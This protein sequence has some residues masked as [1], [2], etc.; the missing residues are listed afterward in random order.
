[1]NSKTRKPNHDVLI[2]F[3]APS[4]SGKTTI[5][6][7]V[8][9][10]M[11]GLVYSVSSTTRPKRANETDDVEYEFLTHEQFM[12]AVD[13]GDFIEYEG[14]HGYQYGTRK[15]KIKKELE[16]GDKLIFDIDVL[17]AL[18]IKKL[19]PAALLIYIDVPSLDVLRERLLSRGSENEKAIE[20]RMKRYSFEKSKASEFDRIVLN[21]DLEQATREVII[22]IRNYIENE[23]DR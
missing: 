18:S 3:S 15:S 21:D 9:S 17:G 20:K 1:M 6:N 8:F 16:R 13:E 4:G 10:E 5:I 23:I 22:I 7:K 19:F 12:E 11:D 2:V 14:V